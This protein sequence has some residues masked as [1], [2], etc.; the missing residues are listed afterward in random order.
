MERVTPMSAK[1]ILGIDFI[2]PEELN[3]FRHSIGLKMIEAGN[4]PELLLTEAELLSIKENNCILFAVNNRMET[5]QLLSIASLR[6]AIG[7]DSAEKIGFYNQDWYLKEPFY[8]QKLEA[9]CWTIL[10]KEIPSAS[11]AQIPSRA[12]ASIGLPSALLVS[13]LFFAYYFHTNGTFLWKHDYIWCS[14]DD[15]NG[16]MIYVGRYEDPA[17]I[18]QNGFSIHRHLK[19]SEAYG[20]LNVKIY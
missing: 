7:L 12:N 18:N 17:G 19:I 11:R 14:D 6:N 10:P 5:D 2:G 8:H 16:D 4:F 1:E 13:Y 20:F 3:V 15:H 9:P